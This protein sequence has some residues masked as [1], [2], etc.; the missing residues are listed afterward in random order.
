MRFERLDDE[1]DEGQLR[2]SGSSGLT[3]APSL[4]YGSGGSSH[5]SGGALPGA[6]GH[7]G[8]SFVPPED[9]EAPSGPPPGDAGQQDTIFAWTKGFLGQ[10]EPLTETTAYGGEGIYIADPDLF[11]SRVY[12]YYSG[13]GF[14]SIGM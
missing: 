11:F 7:R 12:G 9:P 5:G 13:K 10:E 8:Y 1:D 6:G 14:S 3:P 4:V 2:S